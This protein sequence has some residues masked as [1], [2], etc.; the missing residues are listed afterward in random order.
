MTIVR[1]TN[2]EL[3]LNLRFDE[4]KILGINK[5]ILNGL[6]TP[7]VRKSKAPN[8]NISITKKIK[9]DLSDNCVFLYIKIKNRLLKIP[10]NIT[11]LQITKLKLK[12][13]KK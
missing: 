12:F 10:K 1:N 3:V 9:A 7:P 4:E 2:R 13:K 6:V 5:K 11:R 8:C